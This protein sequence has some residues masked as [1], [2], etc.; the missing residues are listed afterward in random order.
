MDEYGTGDYS[1]SLADRVE[2]LE[3]VVCSL[4]EALALSRRDLVYA[5]QRHRTEMDELQLQVRQL[6]NQL[7]SQQSNAGNRGNFDRWG[8]GSHNFVNENGKHPQHFGMVDA[9]NWPGPPPYSPTPPQGPPPDP[10]D[11]AQWEPLS[12]VVD[13]DEVRRERRKWDGAWD[14]WDKEG[15]DWKDRWEKGRKDWK[16]KGKG[17]G[18]D[19]RE[20]Q[21]D[22]GKGMKGRSRGKGRDDERPRRL[23]EADTGGRGGGGHGGHSSLESSGERQLADCLSSAGTKVDISG[24]GLGDEG[25]KR[26][27]DWALSRSWDRAVDEMKMDHNKLSDSGLEE[28]LR[29]V[30]KVPVHKLKLHGNNLGEGCCNV[31]IRMI[32]MGKDGATAKDGEDGEDGEPALHADGGIPRSPVRELHLSHNQIPLKGATDLVEYALQCGLYPYQKAIPLWCRMEKNA[33]TE[34]PT[35]EGVCIVDPSL[36]K[37]ASCSPRH[38]QMHCSVHVVSFQR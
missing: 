1:G 14:E 22:D 9:N 26:W 6:M 27:V 30:A 34:F 5:S 19:W 38:C 4:E 25:I 24:W 35:V 15:R 33:F 23:W 11:A 13:E 18:D 10:D 21:R 12:A 29:F 7:S 32:E 28:L 37:R 2:R 8:D 36:G 3:A 31:L 16:D 20:Y 17:K